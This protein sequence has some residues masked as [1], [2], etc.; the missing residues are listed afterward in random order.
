M[1]D[2]KSNIDLRLSQEIE[3]SAMSFLRHKKTQL[4]AGFIQTVIKTV[5][6]FSF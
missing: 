2:N 5:L 4:R 3:T 6:S 1:N